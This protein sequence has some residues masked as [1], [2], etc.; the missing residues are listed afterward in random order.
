VSGWRTDLVIIGA[1]CSVLLVVAIAA[2]GWWYITYYDTAV[3]KCNRGDLGA[4]VVYEAQQRAQASAELQAQEDQQMAGQEAWVVTPGPGATP[5]VTYSC[6]L[7]V[8]GHDVI[9]GVVADDCRSADAALPI[10]F[11]ALG[12]GAHVPSQ[13]HF[14]CSV[15]SSLWYADVWDSGGTMYGNEAC[16]ALQSVADAG[17]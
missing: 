2:G 10:G 4:C 15:S 11:S 6:Y 17:H 9:V 14:V 1:L 13:D 3:N 5:S 7:G 12:P 8:V 16:S